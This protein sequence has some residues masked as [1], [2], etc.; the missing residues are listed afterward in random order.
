MNAI[1]RLQMIQSV[2]PDW[3]NQVVEFVEENPEFFKVIHLTSLTKYPVGFNKNPH[4][5]FEPNA[6]RNIF[7]TILYAVAC[8]GVNMNYGYQQYV[9]IVSHLRTICIYE[10]N[11]EFP[12]KVQPKKLTIYQNLINLLLQNN[13]NI[14]E[15]T[16]DDLLLVQQVKGIGITTIH[17][18]YQLFGDNIDMVPLSDRNWV[19]GFSK[20]YKIPNPTK[21]QILEKTNKWTNKR[22]GSMYINQ[23]F[24]YL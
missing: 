24:N 8:A 17:L 21:N 6:P 23:C 11:M 13:V 14:N 5:P 19:K 15:M 3:Y 22:V 7:E 16:L 20:F 4:E 10:E 18:C 1:K 9:Q 12:F 2:D